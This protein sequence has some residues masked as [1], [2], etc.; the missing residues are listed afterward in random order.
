MLSL[1]VKKSHTNY[2]CFYDI[3]YYSNS[4]I[5]LVT[6]FRDP[7]AEILTL[8]LEKPLMIMKT[9]PEKP[10]MRSKFREIFPSSEEGWTQKKN[11]PKTEEETLSVSVSILEFVQVVT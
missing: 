9:L 8:I 1:F 5:L 3:I 6:F 10:H 7:L 11:V 2:F 4:E